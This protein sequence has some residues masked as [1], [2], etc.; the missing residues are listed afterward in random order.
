M[1]T[2]S[3]MMVQVRLSH[4]EY[5]IFGRHGGNLMNKF[6]KRNVPAFI[7]TLVMLASLAP[8]A[9]ADCTHDNWGPWITQTKSTCVVPG[10]EQRKCND[11][12]ET[13]ERALELVAHSFPPSWTY[14]NNDVHAKVCSV[15][16][17]ESINLHTHSTSGEVTLKAGCTTTGLRR[18]TCSVCDNYYTETIPATGHSATLTT[19][20]KCKTCGQ[21]VAQ[22]DNTTCTVTFRVGN[23]TSTESVRK[24]SAPLGLANRPALTS[25]PGDHV[26]AGWVQGSQPKPGYRNQPKVSAGTTVSSN[27]TY[28]ALYNLRATG[29]N[30]SLAVGTTGGVLVGT[31]IRN[32]VAAKFSALT[33]ENTFSSIDLKSTSGSGELWD[34]NKKDTLYSEYSYNNLTSSIYYIP[35][36]SGSLG[37]AYTARDSYGNQISGTITL[38]GTPKNSSDIVLRVAPGGTVN[39]KVERFEA[40]SYTH[41]TL[42][43][44]A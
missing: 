2:V 9:L 7:L 40:V 13:Q 12:N 4:F 34:N 42:P 17:E 27:V 26:F 15:C 38:S 14:K 39:F 36:T 31:E 32:K 30:D 33:G 10:K 11:C 1:E 21:Q 8:V 23:S 41:L 18:Y 6:W 5:P 25:V 37:V 24:N 29:Q 35:S 19:D 44:K 28:T 22:V 3:A 16:K 43:T 20:G